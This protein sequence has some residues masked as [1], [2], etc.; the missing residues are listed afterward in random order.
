M[1]IGEYV[2]DKGIYAGEIKD[3][4]GDNPKQLFVNMV[5]IQEEIDF[6]TA[7]EECEKIGYKMPDIRELSQIY[8]YKDAINKGLENNGGEKIKEDWY[9]S[10]TERD[11]NRAWGLIFS[12]G[13]RDYGYK[14][15]T[16]YVRPVL[17]L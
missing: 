13:Y 3:S 6:I 10:S 5:D 11:S 8:H 16:L 7:K 17:A 1:K 14:Y 2:E 15:D 12:S 9:W 4:F